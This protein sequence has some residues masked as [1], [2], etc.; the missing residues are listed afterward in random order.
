MNYLFCANGWIE[1]RVR[2]LIPGSREG[3]TWIEL[4]IE[5]TNTDYFYISLANGVVS[6]SDD[7]NLHAMSRIHTA[8]GHT[9]YKETKGFSVW[10]A[11]G[12]DDERVHLT[13]GY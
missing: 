7:F 8:Q 5:Y 6:N 2:T 13:W 4:P 11:P 1:Q 12:Y 9:T 3:D 10:L